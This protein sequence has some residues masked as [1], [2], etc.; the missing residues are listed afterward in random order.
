MHRMGAVITAFRCGILLKPVLC[1]VYQTLDK[2]EFSNAG[3]AN[4]AFAG[5]HESK[6][7]LST[8]VGCILAAAY[9]V[10]ENLIVDDRTNNWSILIEGSRISAF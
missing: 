2:K 4:P 5:V 9:L 10:R 1:A 8:P 3:L 6:C 7:V